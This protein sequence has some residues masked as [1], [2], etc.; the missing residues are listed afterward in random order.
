MSIVNWISNVLNELFR[1]GHYFFFIIFILYI[2][3]FIIL[4]FIS[5]LSQKFKS[6]L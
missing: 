2:F 6:I 5:I 3:L 4:N 1:N